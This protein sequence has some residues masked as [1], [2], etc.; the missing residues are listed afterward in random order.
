[1][2]DHQ[3]N[4]VITA[5]NMGLPNYNPHTLSV[6]KISVDSKGEHIATCSDDGMII[7]DGLCTDENNQK[8]KLDK[9]IKAV[10]LDPMHYRSGSGRRFLIGE[11]LEGILQVSGA[12][13]GRRSGMG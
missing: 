7:I 3:G 4:R 5:L 10:E 6:N 8:L 12:D 2:L 9:A 1:M 13:E 11:L